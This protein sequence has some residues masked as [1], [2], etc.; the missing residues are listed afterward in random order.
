MSTWEDLGNL[1]TLLYPQVI[2]PV[3]TYFQSTWLYRD[4]PLQL[5]T[6]TL[7]G[8]PRTL[9]KATTNQSMGVSNPKM[10]KFTENR[11]L[12]NCEAET[13]AV[14]AI[15]AGYDVNGGVMAG[16]LSEEALDIGTARI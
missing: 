8:D 7:H 6:C 9:R 12:Y 11:Q 3:I 15:V 14:A 16:L 5:Y 13:V 4:Y 1:L 2:G 10:Y